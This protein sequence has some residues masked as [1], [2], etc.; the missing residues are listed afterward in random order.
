MRRR[1]VSVPPRPG[2]RRR[3]GR[4]RRNHS[5]ALLRLRDVRR[6]ESESRSGRG[7]GRFHPTTA[8]RAASPSRRPFPPRPRRPAAPEPWGIFDGAPG[9]RLRFSGTG[10]GRRGA[11]VSVERPPL[12]G[13]HAGARADPPRRREDEIRHARRGTRAEAWSGG[14]LPVDPGN[15]GQA[16]RAPAGSRAAS[17]SSRPSRG[18]TTTRSFTA[19]QPFRA[20]RA[21]ATGPSSDTSR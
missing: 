15:L 4:A 10:R 14:P 21:G 1:R 5:R 17:A 16:R 9:P 20:P 2:C 11:G 19:A 8:Q 6:G 18:T 12:P 13:P 7:P 3:P